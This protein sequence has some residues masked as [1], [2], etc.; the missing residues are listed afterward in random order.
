VYVADLDAPVLDGPDEHHLRRVL[1][2]RSGDPVAAGDGRGSWRPCRLGGGPV[3]EPSGELRCEPRPAPEVTIGVSLVKGERPELAVGKLTEVGVDRV[4]VLAAARSVVH[5][6]PD[7]AERQVARLCGVARAAARQ[8]RRLWLP[9]VSG[10]VGPLALAGPGVA[11]ADFGG[12]PP[13][14]DRTTVLVGPEG[15]WTDEERAGFDASVTLGPAVLRTETAAIAAGL[16]LCALR[17]GVVAPGR[18]PGS[19]RD[20]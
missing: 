10:P 16:V 15:G 5:W 7:R 1:R 11:I 17:S 14:L 4:V 9:E 8:S 19:P 12:A 6:E 13:G 20:E 2:L 18:A 3:L